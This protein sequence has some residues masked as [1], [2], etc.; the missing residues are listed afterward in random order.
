MWKSHTCF[1]QDIIKKGHRIRK[2]FR[3]SAVWFGIEHTVYVQGLQHI[4]AGFAHHS[5][6]DVKNNEYKF[7]FSPSAEASSNMTIPIGRIHLSS[8]SEIS[9]VCRNFININVYVL[10]NIGI[11]FDRTYML[12]IFVFKIARDKCN[13][14]VYHYC[15]YY[16]LKKLCDERHSCFIMESSHLTNGMTWKNSF[17]YHEIMKKGMRLPR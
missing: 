13:L 14:Y 17:H 12:F 16:Y 3:L 7:R 1:L 10:S 4:V 15:Y 11:N 9:Q 2:Q 6:C 8:F 5:S